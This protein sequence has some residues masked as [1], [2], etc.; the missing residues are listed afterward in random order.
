ML[1]TQSN[2]Q[3]AKPWVY[4]KKWTMVTEQQLHLLTS[5]KYQLIL[6]QQQQNIVKR[7][8]NPIQNRLH[9]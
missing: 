6:K 3:P 4:E 5:R 2:Q 1:R 7:P 9:S 8:L